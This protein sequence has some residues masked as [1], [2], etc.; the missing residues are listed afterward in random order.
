MLSRMT[1]DL[2]WVR[3]AVNE[4]ANYTGTE[5]ED[6]MTRE[7]LEWARS[8]ITPAMDNLVA[9]NPKDRNIQALRNRYNLVSRAVESR[10][11]EAAA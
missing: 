7:H 2:Y 3:R 10:L 9:D 4:L 6:P 1:A 11:R 5:L 8:L